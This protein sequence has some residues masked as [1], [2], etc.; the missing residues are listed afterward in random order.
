MNIVPLV[1]LTEEELFVDIGANDG[2][3][4]KEVQDAYGCKVIGYEPNIHPEVIDG[5]TIYE[6]AVGAGNGKAIIHI[7]GIDGQAD[8]LVERADGQPRKYRWSE[9]FEGKKEVD[10]IPFADI[11]REHGDIGFCNMDCEG[12]EYDI[13]LN[14][15][16]NYLTRCKAFFVEF[17]ID[18]D[19]ADGR[20]YRELT[21]RCVKRLRDCGFSAKMYDGKNLYYLFRRYCGSQKIS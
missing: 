16:T 5:L 3:V 15:H 14:S 1:K 2:A 13:L 8:S 10:V 9:R 7:Y 20:D 17:H 18:G 19:F 11:V 21:A 6:K 4:M 12:S